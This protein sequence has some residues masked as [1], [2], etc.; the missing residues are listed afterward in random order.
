MKRL[1]E[2]R[3]IAKK[4]KKKKNPPKSLILEICEQ[5]AIP[6]PKL[7]QETSHSSRSKDTEDCQDA[8]NRLSDR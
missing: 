4:K 8:D 1:A 5:T 2:S 6:D 7:G 3:N